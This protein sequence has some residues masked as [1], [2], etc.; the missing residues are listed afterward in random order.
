MR[1]RLN[2]SRAASADLADQGS[3]ALT[4]EVARLAAD[5]QDRA[6]GRE[7]MADMETVV[8]DWPA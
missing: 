8:A 2:M 4:S 7:L 1:D 3:A 5:E 6:A